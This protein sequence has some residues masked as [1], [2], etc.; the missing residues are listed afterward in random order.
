MTIGTVNKD[1]R[2]RV[3][4][5]ENA[6]AS[7][8]SLQQGAVVDAITLSAN[9]SWLLISPRLGDADVPIGWVQARFVN[10]DRDTIAAGDT[11]AELSDEQFAE[12]VKAVQEWAAGHPNADEPL[13]LVRGRVL[14]PRALANEMERRT[15]FGW[16]FLNY[17]AHEAARTGE[18][19]AEPI[20]RAITANQSR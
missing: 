4:P 5:D 14:S 1:V 16:P 10:F 11:Q 13:T 2:V 9:G 6:A 19:V 18:G 3:W 8:T 12:I 17:L 20:H 7:P 15:E